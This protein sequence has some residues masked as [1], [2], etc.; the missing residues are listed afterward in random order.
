MNIKRT[1]RLSQNTGPLRRKQESPRGLL[2]VNLY[3]RSRG[4]LPSPSTTQYHHAWILQMNVD[5]GARTSRAL[6]D[7][8]LRNN[9]I[10]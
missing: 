1:A 9:Q 7:E 5:S 8:T 10:F 3:N 6:V 2:Q 4:R